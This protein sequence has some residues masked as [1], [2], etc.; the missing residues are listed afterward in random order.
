[1]LLILLCSYLCDISE[2][3]RQA[4]A[5]G[6]C[7]SCYAQGNRTRHRPPSQVTAVLYLL[8]VSVPC[9]AFLLGRV[10]QGMVSVSQFPAVLGSKVSLTTG[11]LVGLADFWSLVLLFYLMCKRVSVQARDNLVWLLRHHPPFYFILLFVIINPPFLY[12]L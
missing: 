6:D 10:I 8:C 2:K 3:S 12:Y 4:G 11:K 1:M 5:V 7:R 9:P